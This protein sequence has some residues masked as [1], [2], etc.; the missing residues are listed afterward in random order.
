MIDTATIK[1]NVDLLAL[2]GADTTLKRQASTKGGEWAG[3][4]PFCGTGHDRFR[5][6]PN[7]DQPG[8]W[9]RQCERSGDA[10]TYV[11]E[12]D[13]L[14][15]RGACEELGAMRTGKRKRPKLAPTPTPDPGPPPADWQEAARSIVADC[16]AMFWTDAGA[17]AREWLNDRGLNDE[18]LRAWR[19]GFC[20]KGGKHHGLYV[21]RGVTIPWLT[22]PDLW[23][24]NVRTDQT[25]GKPKYRAI[26][27]S[28]SATALYG[29][30]KLTGKPDVVVTE[31]ELDALLV[32][33]EAGDLVDVLTLG[34]AKGRLADR[35]LAALLPVKRFYI[36]TDNDDEGRDAAHHWLTMTG[37]RGKRMAPP[38]GAKDV[39]EYHQGGGHVRGWVVGH[40]LSRAWN[41]VAPGELYAKDET[42]G[43][44]FHDLLAEYEAIKDRLCEVGEP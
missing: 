36:A 18:T 44:R 34:S 32:W 16:E 27:G 2:I 19:L 14:D 20:T 8:W 15:F 25:R 26:R 11:K 9:C 28:R 24:V 6:W 3:P 37:E 38:D 10:I 21:D 4:C 22:G 41:E 7:A 1:Q 5:V 13:G 39:T 17:K 40:L 30:D 31:G 12:R 43:R 23:K 35:W 42:Y 33:Q 29:V